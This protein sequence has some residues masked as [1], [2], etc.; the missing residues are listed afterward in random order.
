MLRFVPYRSDS[1]AHNRRSFQRACERCRKRKKRCDHEN[2]SDGRGSEDLSSSSLKKRPTKDSQQQTSYGG[3]ASSSREKISTSN[4]RTRYA[5]RENQ[6]SSPLPGCADAAQNQEGHASGAEGRTQIS[7]R[8]SRQSRRIFSE[9]GPA[10][11]LEDES[12]F[13]GDLNPEATFLAAASPTAT[14]ASAETDS[15]GVWISRR[16]TAE[17]SKRHPTAV[18]DHSRSSSGN[19]PDLRIPRLFASHLEDACMRLLPVEPDFQ[20][21]YKIYLEDIHPI[22]PVIDQEGFESTPA[23]SPDGVLLRQAIC[24]AASTNPVAKDFLKFDSQA[25]TFPS[26]TEFIR[27]IVFA[28]RTSLNLG[29]VKDKLVL[30]QALSLAGLFTQ[31]ADD[32]D[33]SAELTASA[34]SY[35]HTT[36]L[37]LR[38]KDSTGHLASSSRL[39]CCVWALDRLNA[40]FHGRPVLM[41]ERDFD[42]DLETCFSEQEPCFQLFLRTVLLLDKVIGLYRPEKEPIVPWEHDFPLFGDLVETSN[43]LSVK[44]RLLATIETLYHSVAMLSCRTKSLQTP[45]QSSISYLRQSLSATKATAIVSEDFRGQLCNLPI[46]PYAISLSLRVA[47]RELRLSR[48]PM[49]RMRARKQLL[50]NSTILRELGDIFWSATALANLAEQTVQEMDKVCSSLV[51]TTQQQIATAEKPTTGSNPPGVISPADSS[52]SDDNPGAP[53]SQQYPQSRNNQSLLPRDQNVISHDL[54]FDDIDLAVFDNM[55]TN[56]DVFAHF[57]PDFDLSAVDATI[58]ES[59]TPL[60]PLDLE[61]PPAS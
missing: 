60:L 32:R 36:G 4:K 29:L 11:T 26:R 38:S 53:Q 15:I 45:P 27:E 40:A 17:F 9:D 59:I 19:T 14:M 52:A 10:G 51:Q 55:P 21:L 47:Y 12:R 31:F 34:I 49:L 43:A 18:A 33:I 23:G 46:V 39:F 41:H 58:G 28:I 44:S 57:D 61:H 56:L 1:G 7:T 42:R 24:L 37:H 3:R 6:G 5:S 25:T 2:S 30:I 22:F 35:C 8:S 20:L 13:V 50:V 48:A 54:N 16:P